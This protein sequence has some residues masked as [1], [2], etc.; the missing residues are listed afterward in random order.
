MNKIPSSEFEPVRIGTLAILP[1][2]LACRGYCRDVKSSATGRNESADFSMRSLMVV[3]G[4][5]LMQARICEPDEVLEFEQPSAVVR[6]CQDVLLVFRPEICPDCM[7]AARKGGFVWKDVTRA[8]TLEEPADSPKMV[9]LPGSPP[10]EA[11]LRWTQARAKR[12]SR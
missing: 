2:F 6:F 7:I 1:V 4:M 9:T 10:K 3:A 8:S 5:A 12:W 11:M